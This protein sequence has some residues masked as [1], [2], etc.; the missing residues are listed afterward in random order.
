MR[1][2]GIDPG[3]SI[4][5]AILEHDN[6]VAD[7]GTIKVPPLITASMTTAHLAALKLLELADSCDI[8]SFE[9][10]RSKWVS[11]ARAEHVLNVAMLSGFLLAG[12]HARAQFSAFGLRL[13]SPADWRKLLCGNPHAKPAQI[14]AALADW[15]ITL[16]RRTNEHIRDAIGLAVY[17]NLSR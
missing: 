14:T 6:V 17:Q 16:P 13:V 15:H 5:W 7:C 4:G 2:L 11:A 9:D 8:V 10:I 3:L 12:L 1:I